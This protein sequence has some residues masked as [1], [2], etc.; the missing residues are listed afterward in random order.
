MNSYCIFVTMMEMCIT[1]F[2]KL[3]S[4]YLNCLP[5]TD[6]ERDGGREEGREGWK[7]RKREEKE[8]E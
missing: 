8:K 4:A 2:L 3:I 7:E 6:R 1:V 5:K